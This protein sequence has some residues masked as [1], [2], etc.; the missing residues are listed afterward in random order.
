MAKYRILD[1]PRELLNVKMRD[2]FKSLIDYDV[3]NP[4]KGYLKSFY[5]NYGYVT[6]WYGWLDE[7]ALEKYFR[8]YVSSSPLKK[9][10]DARNAADE[11][12]RA[13]FSLR[14]MLD[15]FDC[16]FPIVRDHPDVLEGGH[17]EV[18]LHVLCPRLDE[19]NLDEAI[20]QLRE[21]TDK[22]ER[23]RD[24]KHEDDLDVEG[25]LDDP[26]DGGFETFIIYDAEEDDEVSVVAFEM[27]IRIHFEGD[28]SLKEKEVFVSG[29]LVRNHRK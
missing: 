22:L 27:R 15:D 18:R 14:D 13:F 1:L 19:L 9:I 17:A 10:E 28:S 8:D 11:E 23:M 7:E 12:S 29:L 5:A 4:E 24:F 21:F 25:Y 3:D 6:F 16:L 26:P 20:V 2:L